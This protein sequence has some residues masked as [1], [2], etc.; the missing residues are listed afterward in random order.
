MSFEFKLSVVIGVNALT[1]GVGTGNS[2][3]DTDD[4][5]TDSGSLWFCLE[6]GEDPRTLHGFFSKKVL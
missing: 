3:I 5:V 2:D 6:G 1:V 4:C